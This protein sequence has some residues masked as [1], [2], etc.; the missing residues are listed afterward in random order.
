MTI[1]QDIDPK[2]ELHAEVTG[3]INRLLL[4]QQSSIFGGLSLH[5]RREINVAMKFRDGER[6][7]FQD[8][9]LLNSGRLG[10]ITSYPAFQYHLPRNYVQAH[11][12]FKD[13]VDNSAAQ[14]ASDARASSYMHRRFGRI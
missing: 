2:S 9:Q 14:N 13:I 8:Y 4:K 7:D 6:L 3:Y 11:E 1:A 10:Q 5:E 12:R